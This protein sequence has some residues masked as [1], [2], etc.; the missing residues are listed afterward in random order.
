[1]SLI[2][3]GEIGK[4]D[5]EF[6]DYLFKEYIPSYNELWLFGTGKYAL[7]F[8]KYLS[9]CGISVDGYVTSEGGV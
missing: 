5:Y 6:M 4:K 2:G 1:M 3:M 7:A 8:T 9:T